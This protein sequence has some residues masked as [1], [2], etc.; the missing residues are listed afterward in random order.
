MAHRDTDNVAYA[1]MV[2]RIIRA[3]ARRVADSDEVDLGELLKV[4]DE[5]DAA[6]QAGVDGLRG[7]GHSWSYVARGAGITR[8]AAQQRWGKRGNA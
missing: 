5:L 1:A 2:R 7:Q 8:Q 4:R 6:I 3:F